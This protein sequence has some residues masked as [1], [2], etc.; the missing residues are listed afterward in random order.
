MKCIAPLAETRSG[1]AG[2]CSVEFWAAGIRSKP[3]FANYTVL[4]LQAAI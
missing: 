4:I 3:T 1:K 2:K